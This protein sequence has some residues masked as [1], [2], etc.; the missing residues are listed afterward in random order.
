[1]TK[2]QNYPGLTTHGSTLST[3]TDVTDDDFLEDDIDD[4]DD[5]VE[6]EDIDSDAEEKEPLD[7]DDVILKSLDDVYEKYLSDSTDEYEAKLEAICAHAADHNDHYTKE[8]FTDIAD[9][10]QKMGFLTE[11][12]M[13]F[14]DETVEKFNIYYW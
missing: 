9:Y 12:Q 5:W 10:Y 11:R 2:Y 7:T 1:M 4:D 8:K 6:Y 14:I 3:A 13:D